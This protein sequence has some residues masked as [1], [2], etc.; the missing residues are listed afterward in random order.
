[1]FM[2]VADHS[3][4]RQI[5]AVCSV[6]WHPR[7]TV[8]YDAPAGVATYGVIKATLRFFVTQDPLCG[9]G[10]LDC[11]P[12]QPPN[13]GWALRL[14]EVA[15]PVGAIAH[16]HTHA[17][18]GWRHLISGQLRLETAHDT[19]TMRGG[20]SWFEPADTPVRAVALQTEGVTRFV[21]CML[22]PLSDI[23]QSTFRLCDASDAALPRLQVTHRHFDHVVQVDA[24]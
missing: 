1:M 16:R 17:G 4:D 11:A 12:L 10:V 24:G 5:D 18:S 2:S 23:G 13:D 6:S 14:D 3:F 9:D 15:F 22:I 7:G 19:K 20:D 8:G 21:R